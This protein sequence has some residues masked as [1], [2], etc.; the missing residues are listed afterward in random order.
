MWAGCMLATALG[1]EDKENQIKLAKADAIQQ[2]VRLLRMNK[3]E[4]VQL[5]VIEV[6]GILCVGE[7]DEEKLSGWAYEQEGE[8]AAV[9]VAYRNNKETQ[10]CIADEGGIME[11]SDLLQEPPSEQVQVAVAVCL[12]RVVLSNRQNQERLQEEPHFHF[13]DIRLQAGMALSIFAYNNTPQQLSLRELGGIKFSI[14]EPFFTSGDEF[15]Q[16]QSAFQLGSRNAA[17]CSRQS[18]VEE[19]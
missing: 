1:L 19:W 11:L 15:Q 10:R 8:R 14:F 2:L 4:S 6:L 5:M 3:K 16:C 17:L 13:D 7:A 12:A 9:G 18:Q